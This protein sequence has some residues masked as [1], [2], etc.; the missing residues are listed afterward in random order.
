MWPKTLIPRGIII[1]MFAISLAFGLAACGSSGSGSDSGSGPDIE[2]D[3]PR[4]FQLDYCVF[5]GCGQ[6]A[7]SETYTTFA[8]VAEPVGS[9]PC[10]SES[11][12]LYPGFIYATSH[13]NS[14]RCML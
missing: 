5:G 3:P 14:Q 2:P 12:R 6:V 1:S 7:S 13:K 4:S 8:S 10:A 11:Y 9:E